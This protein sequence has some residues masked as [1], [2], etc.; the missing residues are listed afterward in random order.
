MSK[1]HFFLSALLGLGLMAMNPLIA[2]AQRGHGG[3]GRGGGHP[4]GG[5]GGGGHVPGGHGSSFASFHHEGFAGAHG[6]NFAFEHR[7][8][9]DGRGRDFSFFPWFGYG[10]YGPYGY[11]Y[12]PGYYDSYYGG[13]PYVYS[14]SPSYVGP[15]YNYMG[16]VSSAPPAAP[17]NTTAELDVSLP[18]ADAQVWVDGKRMPSTPS[19]QRSFVTP[20][21][22]PGQASTYKVTAVWVENGQEMRVER[23]VPVSAGTTATVD[24]SSA[25][26][27]Q[28]VPPSEQ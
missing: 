9:F 26:T 21:L 8:R 14:T 20:P 28:R 10:Y 1:Y 24:F 7:G 19:T 3:G 13:Q 16:P 17:A 22:Q 23:T 15:P 4:G 25:N 11:A 12:G 18:V 27:T 2:E 5:H 6:R